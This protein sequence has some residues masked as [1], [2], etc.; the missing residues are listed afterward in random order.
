VYNEYIQDMEEILLLTLSPSALPVT[1]RIMRDTF[2]L[3]VYSGISVEV[4]G[5]KF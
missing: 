1:D 5:F 4:L 3:E 2:W